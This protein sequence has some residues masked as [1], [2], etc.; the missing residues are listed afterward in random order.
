MAYSNYSLEQIESKFGIKN[1]IVTLFSDIQPFTK[2]DWLKE[3]LAIASE[4]PSHSEKAKS[5]LFVMPMLLE[6][7]N[8]NSKFFTI[9]SGETLEADKKQ[10]LTGECDFILSKDVKSFSINCPVLQI[11]EAKKH[12]IE[13]GVGQC[14]AQLLGA[15]IFN[16]KRNMNLPMVYGCVTNKV[17][18]QFLKLENN[19]IYLHH[20]V[21]TYAEID[22]ILGAFQY[23]I[24][25]Y[26]EILK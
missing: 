4:L 22:Y 25:Y 12:D 20:H 18:W 6:L 15:R 13:H 14:A 11:V 1:Q 16:E 21:Y 5:E 2:S 26:K 8:R 17:E 24:D 10:G 7:R 3:S 9:Y 19:T 23:I